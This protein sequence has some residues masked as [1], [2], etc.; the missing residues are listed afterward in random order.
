M[1]ALSLLLDGTRETAARALGAVVCAIIRGADGK[2]LFDKGQVIGVPDLEGLAALSGVKVPLLVPEEGDVHEDAAALRLGKLV[3]GQGIHVHGPREARA[4]LVA[5]HSGVFRVDPKALERLNSV[6][7]VCVYTLFDRQP[8]KEGVVVA[9]AKVT[10]LLVAASTLEQAAAAVSS[11]PIYVAPFKQARAAALIRERIGPNQAQRIVDGLSR[12]LAWFGAS[13]G[14]VRYVS[15]A[16]SAEA[17][18]G[19]MREVLSGGVDLL[20][21]SGGSVADPFDPLLNAL[22]HVPA[23]LYRLGVPAHPGSMLWLAHAGNVPIV[24]VPSCGSFSEATA[25]D[26]VLPIVLSGEPITPEA[27]ASLAEGGLLKVNDHRLPAYD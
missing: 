22:E 25:F 8:V 24:G 1:Y 26:L 5:A 21:T 19:Q 13:L 23:S 4:R 6:E 14:E 18:A 3:A 12:K 7:G 11:P 20:L 17:V 16:S 9:E 27:L 15:P 10:P 2:R